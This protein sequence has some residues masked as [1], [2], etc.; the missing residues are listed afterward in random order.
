MNTFG[1]V[2]FHTTTAA[3]RSEKTLKKAGFVV[4]LIPVPRELS[5]N[6]GIA[7]RFDWSSSGQIKEAL[8]NA[9]VEIA[10]VHQL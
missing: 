1:V 2:L 7:L 6:C 10:G 5:S 3:L 8:E 4:K 9:H